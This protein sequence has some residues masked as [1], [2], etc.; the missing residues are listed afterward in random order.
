MV[1]SLQRERRRPRFSAFL[2]LPRFD[3]AIH[4]L[5]LFLYLSALSVSFTAACTRSLSNPRPA[6]ALRVSAPLY[7]RH[8]GPVQTHA[9]KWNFAWNRAERFSVVPTMNLSL[10]QQYVISRSSF[11]SVFLIF[12]TLLFIQTVLTLQDAV[13]IETVFL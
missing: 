11:F 6:S 1:A 3:R 12:R 10:H 2:S 8:R 4:S 9:E 5:S 13:V 7:R